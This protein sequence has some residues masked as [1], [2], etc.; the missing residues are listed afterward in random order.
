MHLHRYTPTPALCSGLL[1]A[2]LG[3][4]VAAPLQAD[5]VFTQNVIVDAK[6]CVGFQCAD[7][8]P[9][10]TATQILLDASDLEI[11]FQ[12]SSTS[13]G[14]PT[15]DWA[16][17]AND[18]LTSSEHFAIRNVTDG[19][20]PFF[21]DDTALTNTLVLG[22]NGRVGISTMLPQQALHVVGGSTTGIRQQSTGSTPYNWDM[23]ANRFNW[24]LKNV[25]TNRVPVVVRAGAGDG[26]LVISDSSDIGLGTSAPDAALHVQRGDNTAALLIEETGAGPLGQL[27][28]RNNGI[29]YLT[30]EDTSIT[31]GN[32]TGRSWNF[33]NQGGTF[34]VT[35]APGGAGDIEMILTP[36]GDL[37]IEGDYFSNGGTPVPDYVFDAGYDL[38]PL[39]QVQD[40]IAVNGHLPDVP[41]AAQVAAEG[42]NVSR[43]Q[44]ALL[45]KIEEL[46]LY[47]LELEQTNAAQTGAIAGLTAR[48][49]GI[50]AQITR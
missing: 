45:R 40:F 26:S 31:A 47:T 12:D 13:S 29:T 30:L 19:R 11:R 43:M 4:F 10:D 21:I 42:H 46:T 17:Q 36:A 38:R 5:E 16:L 9:F 48:L 27:T 28:L 33:Q 24:F 50:E 35:T 3:A 6:L 25:T 22:G 23:L 49:A 14:L 18:T 41:S 15:T 1:T 2:A 44:M 34:R 20:I 32:D 7:G 37:T 8:E 39:D